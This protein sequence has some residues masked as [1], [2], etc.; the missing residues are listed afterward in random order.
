MALF[1]I[2]LV[3]LIWINRYGGTRK[4]MSS[5]SG[6]ANA[7]AI[8]EREQEK[9]RSKTRLCKNNLLTGASFPVRLSSWG[10][11]NQGL[12]NRLK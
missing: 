11:R 5:T 6:V 4:C 7:N 10:S 9:E 2:L 3:N 1:Y 12:M 8:Q